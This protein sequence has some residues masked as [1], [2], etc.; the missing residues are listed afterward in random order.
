VT[1]LVLAA[2]DVSL[3][4]RISEEPLRAAGAAAGVL[5]LL[6]GAGA[7][8]WVMGR[9]STS[10]RA[11]VLALAAT[12]LGVGAVVA[13]AL[14]WLGAIGGAEL[15]ALSVVLL[16][17]VP[18]G[19]LLAVVATTRLGRDVRTLEATLLQMAGGDRTVRAELRRVDELGS[20]AL[21][22][23]ELNRRLGE[24]E[25]ERDAVERERA[26]L[27]SSISHDLRTPLA[28]LRAAVEA[29]ADGVASDPDR[30]LAAMSR[31]VD[32]LT[33]LVDNLFLLVRL[34][35]GLA[36]L[37]CSATDVAELAEDC[38]EGLLPSAEQR[39][40]RLEVRAP[41]PAPVVADP[42]AVA[43]VL[44]NLVG[45]AVRH[46]PAGTSVVV[47]VAALPSGGVRCSVADA[48]AG[49]DP[50]VAGR[51]FEP[52]VRAEAHRGRDGGAGLGLAIVAAL[53]A[54]HGGEVGIDADAPGGHVWF[55]L[56]AAPPAP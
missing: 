14:A 24:L 7:L 52:F 56:P 16:L 4:S 8:L 28:A 23:D 30:Y 20:V 46:A 54:A 34:D 9:R 15:I 21:A 35:A 48:G 49:F 40:V 33:G 27:L 31:D 37:E 5:A 38:V 22:V 12:M 19:S 47:D 3:A 29:L 43:R 42:G 36:S 32:A 6:A 55:S 2:T 50:V 17:M 39:S 45:N 44:A 10:L 51:A 18:V 1:N 25:E 53:V 41:R 26:L 11:Q 13:V